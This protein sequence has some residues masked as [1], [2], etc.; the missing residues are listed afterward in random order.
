MFNILEENETTLSENSFASF[1][2]LIIFH[3]FSRILDAIL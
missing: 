3:Q 2:T 1:I